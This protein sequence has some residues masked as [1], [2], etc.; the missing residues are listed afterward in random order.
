MYPYNFLKITKCNKLSLSLGGGGVS[1]EADTRPCRWENHV[2]SNPVR[3]VALVN[4]C[5]FFR[6]I[7]LIQREINWKEK[8]QFHIRKNLEKEKIEL[9][10]W[11][12]AW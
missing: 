4:K 5:V 12:E 1:H 2:E 6:K 11:C 3:L 7:G 9:H 8:T 10:S